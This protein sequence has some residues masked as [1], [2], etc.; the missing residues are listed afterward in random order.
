MVAGT[1]VNSRSITVMGSVISSGVMTALS[2]KANGK[3][4][5]QMGLGLKDGQTIV[6]ILVNGDREGKMV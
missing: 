6:S 2:M 4:I 5:I 3:I 1:L